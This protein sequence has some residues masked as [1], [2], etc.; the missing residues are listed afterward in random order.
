MDTNYILDM[1][2]WGQ[3]NGIGLNGAIVEIAWFNFSS[4]EWH[5]EHHH[6]NVMEYLRAEL[7]NSAPEFKDS[8]TL[9]KVVAVMATLIT[10]YYPGW[11][12][13]Q[14]GVDAAEYL[15]YYLY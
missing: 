7:N 11:L 6:G 15:H 10:G 5:G 4:F 2:V 14:I 9:E 8:E 1:L 3:R 12:M 13:N